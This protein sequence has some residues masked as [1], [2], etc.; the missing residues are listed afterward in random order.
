MEIPSGTSEHHPVSQHGDY[1]GASTMQRRRVVV[2][3][4]GFAGLHAV[5]ALRRAPVD[6]TL[7]DRRN[8]HLFQPLLYQVATGGL[9][10]GNIAAPL[11]A[12]VR[13]QQNCQVLLA[14][15]TDFDLP[16][17]RVI[18]ADG[19]LPFDALL[20][21]AG[22]QTGY[23]GHPEWEAHAPGLKSIEDAL[24]IRRRILLAFEHAERETDPEQRRASLTFVI[25][26]GGP[27]GVELAGTLAEIARYTLSH[28][29]RRVDP[30]EAQIVL[31]DLASR[32]LAVYPDRLSA[33]ALE[34]LERLHITVKLQARVTDLGPT[35]ISFEQHGQ[36][37]VLATRTV[38]WAAGVEA[39]PLGAKLAAAAG[40][41][42]DR[43]GRVPVQPDLSLAGFPQVYVLGDL[44]LCR[45]EQ[46]RPLPGVAPVAI[47][48]GQ[49][50]ADALTRRHQAR[51]APPFR[52]HDLGTLA[53][54]GRRAAVG[55]VFGR[56]VTGVIAWLLWL[57]IHLM[58]LVRFENRLLVLIQWAWNYI[59]FSRST[60][61]ITAV[62]WTGTPRRPAATVGTRGP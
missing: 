2:I 38:L 10:P 31:L 17:Q 7:V 22:A 33:D 1:Q 42:C 9:S 24:E 37:Q 20:V 28:E 41:E 51:V 11:R 8:F 30:S 12:V 52:Y 26:G 27:T 6:I 15:V 34:R 40:L 53:T 43:Q 16:Q 14:D 58:Q 5:R 35:Q 48:Q 13:H 44:A 29:F 60:R 4:G 56:Q 18:L 59:T 61:L 21:C 45:D 55:V 25:V 3:G 46:G 54:I 62:G 49:Y 47:Q 23:F 39:S 36:S 19:T 50:V 57:F 32:V